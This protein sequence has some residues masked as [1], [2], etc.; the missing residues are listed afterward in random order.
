MTRP[1]GLRYIPLAAATLVLACGDA[2]TAP[3][4]DGETLLVSLAGISSD[5]AGVVLELTGAA[6]D[7]E[8]AGV[9]LDVAWVRSAPN[10]VTVAIVGPLTARAHVLVVKRRAGLE[11]LRLEVREVAAADGSVSTPPAARAIARLADGS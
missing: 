6:E 3:N 2:A 1:R 10:V 4:A 5:D 8:S 9:A 7:I 11:P